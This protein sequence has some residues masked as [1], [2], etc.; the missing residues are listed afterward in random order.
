MKGPNAEVGLRPLL[1]VWQS[2]PSSNRLPDPRARRVRAPV[3]PA[4][5][6]RP[7]SSSGTTS[8]PRTARSM[9]EGLEGNVEF[10][11]LSS[12]DRNNLARAKAFEARRST[13]G[14]RGNRAQ[15]L[16][17]TRSGGSNDCE[18]PEDLRSPFDCRGPA[19][20]RDPSSAGATDRWTGRIGPSKC[21]GS[22]L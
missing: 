18:G 6:S 2:H 10:F 9:A 7:V 12:Q 11:E 19:T 4:P 15:S 3:V 17:E 14:V 5:R 21:L 13:Q 20:S 22:G 1:R 16:A 8:T